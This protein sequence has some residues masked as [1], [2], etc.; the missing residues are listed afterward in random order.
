MRPIDFK[1]LYFSIISIFAMFK[2]NSLMN[3]IPLIFHSNH[4]TVIVQEPMA[5]FP[6]LCG[7]LVFW[8]T[9]N[10][11]IWALTYFIRCMFII[12]SCNAY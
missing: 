9:Q 11:P 4:R 3:L 8:V 6:L 7:S 2:I 5:K 10:D 12:W 1:G